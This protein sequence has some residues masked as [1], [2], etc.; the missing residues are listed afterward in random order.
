MEDHRNIFG[1][2]LFGQREDV[3]V[4]QLHIEDSEV[5]L[6]LL[7]GEHGGGDIGIGPFDRI[8]RFFYRGTQIPGDDR[9]IFRNENDWLAHS[10]VLL[11]SP[12]ARE[13]SRRVA[14]LGV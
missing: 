7:I 6:L 14:R 12:I 8:A 2:H 9:F 4:S 1:H 3:A 5:G 13:V 11:S 10:S